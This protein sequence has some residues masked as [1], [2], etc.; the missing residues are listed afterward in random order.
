MGAGSHDTLSVSWAFPLS[1]IRL[2]M[3]PH[4]PARAAR[5]H[6]RRIAAGR[7][8]H[9]TPIVS[10]LPTTGLPG[11]EPWAGADSVLVEIYIIARGGMGPQTLE[12]VRP[13]TVNTMR[14]SSGNQIFSHFVAV[15]LLPTRRQIR[16][17]SGGLTS[18]RR[19]ARNSNTMNFN[20]RHRKSPTPSNSSSWIMCGR[21]PIARRRC[22][23][24][25]WP[26]SAR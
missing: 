2:L 25:G 26:A 12:G 24:R 14:H 22:A 20:I 17:S 8:T 5:F 4:R 15:V 7:R 16:P 13:A 3:L 1:T 21:I 18:L 19:S 23:A 6:D 9:D 11:F 10:W